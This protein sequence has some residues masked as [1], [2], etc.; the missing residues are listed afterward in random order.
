MKTKFSILFFSILFYSGFIILCFFSSTVFCQVIP[1]GQS[2]ETLPIPGD[3]TWTVGYYK[4]LNY[5]SLQSEIILYC[6]GQGGNANEGYTL[7]YE[8]ADRRKA[9]I[10]SPTAPTAPWITA[11][12][13]KWL[14][15]LFKFLYRH[16]LLRENRDTINVRL[17]GFSAG[18]QCV[19]RYM[20]I[21]Q[22]IADSIPI[23]MAVS[24]NPYYYTFPIDTLYGINFFWQTG[25]GI[26]Q[27]T[28]NPWYS[29][30]GSYCQEHVK[31]YYNENYT[32][33]IG[34]AD[35]LPAPGPPGNPYYACMDSQGVNRYQRA[36]N[37]Y[38]FS[39][40]N[41]IER[42]TT[43]QWYYAEVPNIGHDGYAMINTKAS[44]TDTVTICEHYLFDMPYHEPQKFPP[45]ADFYYLINDTTQCI[46]FN[47]DC[48]CWWQ[49]Q[50]TTYTWNFSNGL[51]ASGQNISV[52]IPENGQYDVQLIASNIYGSDSIVKTIEISSLPVA[53][54]VVSDT[55][56]TIGSFVYFIN[57]SQN[58]DSVIWHFGDGEE[59]NVE[60]TF[61]VYDS[62]GTY[63]VTLIA[64]NEGC[65]D[66]ITKNII[67]I[68]N[69]SI[70]NKSQ[71]IKTLH[72]YPN[73]FSQTT[74][75]SFALQES[76]FVTIEIFNSIGQRI[77]VVFNN[78]AMSGELFKIDYIAK[79]EQGVYYSVLRSAGYSSIRKF[80]ILK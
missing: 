45:T 67:V 17:I 80:I 65:S 33:L 69:N 7:L 73:P 71:F 13:K 61:H 31:G 8:I 20:L 60:N 57:T 25:C 79:M 24:V 76:G 22:G 4:P 1:Y 55:V 6:H 41:A 75:F 27:D 43:L 29:Y 5:D 14:P 72:I 77:D 3:Y 40:Q 58:A 50:P 39:L 54:F 78:S 34:T 36:V 16:I 15:E 35:T 64:T 74:T 52:D 68:Y 59:S 11:K 28:A 48:K 44:L 2:V 53:L 19:T 51:T 66:T 37:F 63:S 70:S 38:N 9:L 18:G 32:V 12:S 56:V 62:T 30:M 23:K 46:E 10:I 21:K 26:G 47:A 42:G 49:T